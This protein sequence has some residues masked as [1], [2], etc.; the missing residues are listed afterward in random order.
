VA[1]EGDERLLPF[2]VGAIGDDNLCF[3]TD[4]P[5]P[6]HP[7]YGVVD[8]LKQMAGLSDESKRKIL[9]ANAARL[10]GLDLS[11]WTPKAQDASKSAA[12]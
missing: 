12:A 1:A 9:G 8:G 6:D 5:H 3:S 10:F 11:W 7:F 4:Y 2:T